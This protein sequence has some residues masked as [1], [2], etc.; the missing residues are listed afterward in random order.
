MAKLPEKMKF[1]RKE[2]HLHQDQL[3]EL[4]GVS[5]RS[6]AA[7][8]T[9]GVTP[10]G[11]TLLKLADALQVSTDYLSNDSIDVAPKAEE[12]NAVVMDAVGMQDM[13]SLLTQTT[14]LFAGGSIDQSA[15]DAFFESV[16]KAYLMCKEEARKKA[17]NT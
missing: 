13:M 16:M 14:A 12:K 7:Y 10:R 1:K 17:D 5:K 15:K 2:L 8:E 11:K 4:V 3:A 6:I 9:G